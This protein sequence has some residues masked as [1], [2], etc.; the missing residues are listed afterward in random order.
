MALC[1]AN[2]LLY[3][4]NKLIF[5][6]VAWGC[7]GMVV[8]TCIFTSQQVLI[9]PSVVR[10][11]GIVEADFGESPLK[12]AGYAFAHGVPLLFP[13][14]VYWVKK[15]D[16]KIKAIWVFVLGAV[17]FFILKA[18]FGASL[19]VSFFCIL[20]SFLITSDKTLNIVLL[21]TMMLVAAL[22]LNKSIVLSS[23]QLVEPFFEE[24]VIANKIS[25]IKGSIIASG[26]E[27][28]VYNRGALY[29]GS[30]K[31]FLGSPLFGVTYRGD[32]FIGGHS[33][34]LDNLAIGG[35]SG[36][37]LLVLIIWGM[38]KR[39]ILIIDKNKR[40][41]FLISLS[42][43]VILNC[44]KAN[45]GGGSLFILFVVVPALS[46]AH[47]KPNIKGVVRGE[48]LEITQY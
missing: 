1:L 10:S 22:F 21:V 39:L 34:V 35:L 44:V 8:V 11:G 27:G 43:F 6:T 32:A 13:Y 29:L 41:Y 12:V 17:S 7:L 36:F 46:F 48:Q 37:S 19:I 31:A 16:F 26:V 4:K 20:L 15:S 25:D 3:L 40:I 14:L 28:S 9:D 30:W 42:V 2:A 18:N 38:F 33:F 23:L 24:T 47:Y 5:K 45:I